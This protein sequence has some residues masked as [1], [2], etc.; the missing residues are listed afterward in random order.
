M[1]DLNVQHHFYLQAFY[2]LPNH[3]CEKY[4]NLLCSCN[5]NR[6]Q[7]SWQGTLFEFITAISAF[8]RWLILFLW[9]WKRLRSEICILLLV[10]RDMLINESY[11]IS[12]FWSLREFTDKLLFLWHLLDRKLPK[13]GKLKQ[14]LEVPILTCQLHVSQG[15]ICVWAH[16]GN[17]AFEPHRKNDISSYF[18]PRSFI[19]TAK[20]SLLDEKIV[21]QSSY[22]ASLT[23]SY[24]LLQGK[25]LCFGS[26]VGKSLAR[27][28]L[29]RKSVV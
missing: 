19:Q 28:L 17:L 4:R 21:Y 2:T 6:L 18:S 9:E 15:E 12:S 26:R 11:H 13:M 25:V 27:C 1:C 7:T 16:V 29:D 22:G 20:C 8:F 23:L 5:A 10:K 3:V 14:S 24:F